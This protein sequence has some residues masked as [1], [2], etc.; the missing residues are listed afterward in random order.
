[1]WSQGPAGEV[2]VSRG[3]LKTGRAA[4]KSNYRVLNLHPSGELHFSTALSHLSWNQNK[5]VETA[6]GR[7]PA[8]QI[9]P[10]GLV[11][12]VVSLVRLVEATQSAAPIPC[13]R[14]GLMVSLEEGCDWAVCHYGPKQWGWMMASHSSERTAWTVFNRPTTTAG[15]LVRDFERFLGNADRVAR[16]LL[17]DIFEADGAE[18]EQ[19]PWFTEDRFTPAD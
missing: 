7:L 16:A 10:Y 18:V 17:K 2:M 15:P 13:R 9:D 12:T 8:G 11:E 6:L 5:N 14:L 19:I 3:I 1:M 4:E